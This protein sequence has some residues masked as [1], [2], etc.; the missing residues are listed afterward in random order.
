MLGFGRCGAQLML[1]SLITYQSSHNGVMII[2]GGTG[3]SVLPFILLY[4]VPM[5][6]LDQP[7]LDAE[8]AILPLILLPVSFAYAILRHR[9]LNVGL[10]QRWLIHG[11]VWIAVSISYIVVL[12]ELLIYWR[13]TFFSMPIGITLITLSVI[14]AGATFHW[15]YIKT[16]RLIDHVIF[17]DNYDYRAVLQ[18][19]SQ[20]ISTACDMD[21]LGV[22]LLH[23]LR[24]LI[25]A[26]FVTLLL[27][28]QKRHRN[29]YIYT[30][31]SPPE[32]EAGPRRYGKRT[33]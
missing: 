25:N 12:S 1:H 13:P 29:L 10:F 20:D 27:H 32:I 11:L 21:T 30:G 8:H 9:V 33:E 5:L 6:V 26:E 31:T 17:K 18:N 4:L 16:C 24:R 23:T 15:F 2:S 3:V 7:I 28:S 14:S 19:L 22:G